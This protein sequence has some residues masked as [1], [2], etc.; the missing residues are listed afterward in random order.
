MSV[1]KGALLTIAI[2]NFIVIASANAA[3]NDPFSFSGSDSTD[4]SFNV[5][6]LY[7][8]GSFI[9][10]DMGNFCN[11]SPECDSKDIGWELYGGYHWKDGIAAELQY[12]AAGDVQNETKNIRSEIS[13][14]GLHVAKSIPLN[15]KLK[16]F[17]KA[18]MFRWSADNTDG[19]RSGTDWSFGIGST[20]QINDTFRIRGE[21]QR[22][23]DI[24]TS[25]STSSEVDLLS[26]GVELNF[27]AFKK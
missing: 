22:A 13:G 9:R 10:S 20:Y 12:I 3:A 8:G 5:N 23:M 11:N 16:I 2:V 25:L 4:P 21:W 1:R 17:G 7:Y 14:F 18:G 26:I 15:E 6:K 24:E 27:K 19:S